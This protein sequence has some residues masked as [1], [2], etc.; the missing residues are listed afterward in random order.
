M[1]ETILDQIL[2]TK[3]DELTEFRM[4]A[5]NREQ[6]AIYSLKKALARPRHR[7][8]LIAEIKEASPSKGVFRPDFNAERLAR[9]YAASGADAISVLT[10]RFYFHGSI[11]R[12]RSVR[13]EVR[14]PILRKDFI[15]DERQIE[16]AYLCGADAVLLIAAAM[17][18]K[19][20][21][22]LYLT[23]KAFGL[24]ALVEVHSRQEAEAVLNRFT[25]EIVGINNRDLKT[26]RTDLHVIEKIRPMIP[27][28][29][30]IV[31]ESGVQTRA[32]IQFL[33]ENG[34]N[35]ALIGETLIRADS[36]EKKIGALYGKVVARDA[37][38]H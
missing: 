12:L 8:G 3:A 16:E 34:A 22:Q 37:T 32:D 30:L 9:A 26:F 33:Q 13:R 35:A 11:E 27:Q 20:L 29:V 7:F 10:D 1:S 17:E 5:F 2:R 14:L 38:L 6:P 36:P 25:P 21:Y 23:V 18:T 4:P 28:S 15:I 19:Q 31:S 24:E